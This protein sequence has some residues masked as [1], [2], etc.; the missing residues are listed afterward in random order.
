MPLALENPPERIGALRFLG[1]VQLQSADPRLG[2]ISG[3]L[4]D[5]A[6]NL[7]AVTDTGLWVTARIDM[8]NDRLAGVSGLA[9]FPIRDGSGQP[10]PRGPMADAESLARL[11]D[12][13]LL[14]GFERWHRIRRFA[15]PDAPGDYFT[16][17]P[18]L[19]TAS[20]NAA[21]ESLTLLADGRLLALEEGTDETGA[22]R[23]AW[24]GGA[25]GWTT[26]AYRPA[27]LFRPT[28]AAGL[29]DSGGFQGG[30]LVLERSFAVLRGFGSRI[31]H[32]SRAQLDAAG[33]GTVL[34]P[35]EVARIVPPLTT[36][37]FEG[38]AVARR[39]A[40]GLYVFLVSDDNFNALQRTLL[41]AFALEGIPLQGV[42]P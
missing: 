31:T 38:I 36:E 2:G 17:P 12:G 10:L 40:G 1:G 28:D 5:D 19:E 8:A 16:A 20:G 24:L 32:V 39:P 42:A 15:R 35:E 6:L 34:E 23:R 21:L 27:E 9:L 3:L 7:T 41:F 11:P 22:P 18:G 14:V 13:S 4:V 26:L 33:P 29:P 37:N 30:A 25:G